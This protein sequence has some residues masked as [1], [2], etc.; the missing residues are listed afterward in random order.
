VSGI[1]R[2]RAVVS[3]RVQGVWYRDSA[4]REAERLGVTGSARNLA[5]G[6][7]S[8]EVEGPEAAVDAF[9]TWAAEGPP[10]AEVAAVQV[11]RAEPT[12][13]PGFTVG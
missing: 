4:R 13:Q 11:E 9:L 5:D 1:V 12:G 6:T 10:R 7:V 3:G 8:L 2:R